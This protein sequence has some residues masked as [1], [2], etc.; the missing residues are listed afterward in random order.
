[1]IIIIIT[2][3]TLLLLISGFLGIT[4][5][6]KTLRKLLLNVNE[7]KYEYRGRLCL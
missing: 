2:L 7:S 4:K 1:M 5:F 3:L 6:L